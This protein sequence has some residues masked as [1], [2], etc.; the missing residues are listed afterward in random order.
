MTNLSIIGYIIITHPVISN[1]MILVSDDWCHIR[2][3]P[4]RLVSYA[5]LYATIG[6]VRKKQII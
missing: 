3:R 6:D 1:I 4:A 2:M 5:F